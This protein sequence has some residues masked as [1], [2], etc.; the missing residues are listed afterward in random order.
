MNAPRE[1]PETWMDPEGAA[2]Y[3]GVS[4]WTI[5]RWL[6]LRQLPYAQPSGRTGRIRIARSDI[7]A[8]L[9]AATVPASAGPLAE[10]QR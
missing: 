10:S 3:A 6:K 1:V 5:R 2:E 8:F 7:D 4:L 9:R